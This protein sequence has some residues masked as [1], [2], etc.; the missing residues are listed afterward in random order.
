MTLFRFLQFVSRFFSVYSTLFSGCPIA[1]T[2]H[3]CF[4]FYSFS[5][6][7]LPKCS[8]TMAITEPSVCMFYVLCQISNI[9]LTESQ[10]LNV[11]RLAVAFV[12]SIEARCWVKN[13]E[14]VGAAPIGDGPT[15]SE[16]STILLPVKV[17]LML[18]ICRYCTVVWIQINSWWL[19]WA[20]LAQA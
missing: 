14:V 9:G 6:V 4:Q 1:S 8:P 15:T 19:H 2:F 10:H 11:S 16:S 20:T 18:E 17:R 13:E 7:S 5:M 12:Q 3:Q